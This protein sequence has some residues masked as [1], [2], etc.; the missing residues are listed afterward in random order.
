MAPIM[1]VQ[2]TTATIIEFP[3]APARETEPDVAALLKRAWQATERLICALPSVRQAEQLK[4]ADNLASFVK[5][6]D[7]VALA[8]EDVFK[9]R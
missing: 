4:G 8:A 2:T 7:R 6:L 3:G 5:A 1:P 9:V